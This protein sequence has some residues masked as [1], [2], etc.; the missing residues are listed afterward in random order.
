MYTALVLTDNSRKSL[1]QAIGHHIPSGWE[2]I[3]HHMTICMGT[4]DTIKTGVNATMTIDSIGMDDRVLAVGVSS[5]VK[6][7]NKVKHITIA[8]N[9]SNGG[10]PFHS[11]QLTFT[12]FDLPL[13]LTG[14]IEV[15]Q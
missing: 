14:T 2:I 15:C 6:S 8:V 5:A 12:A 13:V 7:T 9:R 4:D 11:N 10:K 3:A 1:L